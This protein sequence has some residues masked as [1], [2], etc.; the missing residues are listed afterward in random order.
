MLVLLH[1]VLSLLSAGHALIMKRDPRSALG[2]ITICLTV[3]VLGPFLYWSMGVNRLRRQAQQWQERGR[4]LAGRPVP[5]AS[6]QAADELPQQGVHLE[7]LR[8]LADRVV[9]TRLLPGNGIELLHN[10]EEAYPAMLAAIEGAEHSVNLSTYIFDSDEVGC[11]FAA[12]LIRAAGRGVAVRIIIDGLGEKYSHPYA[13]KLF[14]GSRVQVRQYLP[15]RQGI[16]V[17]LRNHRKLLVIDGTA[18]FTGGMNIG[19]RHLVARHDAPPVVRDLHFRVTGPV[20][21]DLQKVFLEDWYFV[22]GEAVDDGRYFPP[23]PQCG[24]ALARVISDGPDKELS[25]LH[26]IIMGALACSRERVEIMTPYFIPDRSLI[27]ALVTASLRGVRVTLVLPALN[28]L[29]YVHWAS[30]AYLW[31]LLQHGI[32][33]FHQPP[34]FVHTKMLIVDGVWSLIGSANLDPRS[35]RLNFELNL[36]IYDPDVRK[37]LSDEFAAS[38]DLSHETTLEEMDGRSLPVKLRDSAAKLFSPY[39]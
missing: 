28:N 13:R 7:E 37:L 30:R 15:L 18:A 33:I 29:P 5:V 22:S 21:A 36:E 9:S 4:R 24:A 19:K 27:S 10:G 2:W 25:K 31:E 26:W 3:P 23:L 34:P 1:V 38:V 39:L 11:L 32:R 35:L 6:Q 8:I 12:A 14:K 16:Y 20:V 17:N